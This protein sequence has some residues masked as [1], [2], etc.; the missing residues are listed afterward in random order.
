MA[1]A[2]A[3]EAVPDLPREDAR[4]L[5][6]VLRDLFDHG[7]RGDSRLRAAD[8]ARLDATRLVVPA[9][10]DN[11]SVKWRRPRHI[12]EGTRQMLPCVKKEL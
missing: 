12:I 4:A 10:K 8:L 3:Q 1:D 2:L 5:G 11:V 7:G 6:L 9:D